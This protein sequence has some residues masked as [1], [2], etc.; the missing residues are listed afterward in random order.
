MPTVQELAALVEAYFD[1]CDEV[2]RAALADALLELGRP[3][4]ARQVRGCYLFWRR[5]GGSG[6]VARSMINVE[7]IAQFLQIRASISP[8]RKATMAFGGASCRI[9]GGKSDGA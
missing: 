6:A 3:L 9:K 4:G 7:S 1:G 8:K 2:T 5:D